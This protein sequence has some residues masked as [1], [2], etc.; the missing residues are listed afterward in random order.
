MKQN[1]CF[2]LPLCHDKTSFISI[3]LLSHL[4]PQFSVL[5]SKGLELCHLSEALEV[6]MDEEEEMGKGKQTHK[7]SVLGDMRDKKNKP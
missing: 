2:C 1:K 4:V 5:G 6:E 3:V 7:C